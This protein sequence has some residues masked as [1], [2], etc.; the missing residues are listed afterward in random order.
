[1]REILIYQYLLIL[2]PLT[3]YGFLEPPQ[4]NLAKHKK[5]IATSTCGEL[6]GKPYREIFCSLAS[7]L[8]YTPYQQMTSAID[9]N[10]FREAR[11]EHSFLREGQS[12]DICEAN[13]TLEH[14][15]SNM[16]DGSN[17]WWQSPPL[18][19]GREYEKVNITIDLGQ[20]FHV[21]YIYIAM[22][23]SP[24]PATWVLERSTDSGKTFKPWQYFAEHNSDCARYFGYSSLAPITEDDSV[25]CSSEYSKLQPMDNGEI[26]INLLEN[27][28]GRLNFSNSPVLQEFA[29]ATN[30]RLRLLSVATLHGNLM[31][32][33]RGNDPT[34]TRRYFYAIKE[35]K[36]GG[37]CACHGHAKTC[38]YL[39]K[40]RSDKLICRCEHNTCGDRCDMCCPG[41]EQKKWQLSRSGQ[42]FECEKCNC[43]GHTNDCVYDEE[44]DRINGSI[45]IH[46]KYSGGGRCLNCQHN[47]KG[48]NCNECVDG[49]YKPEGKKWSDIDVCKKCS[50]DPSKHTGRCS[51][52]TGKCECLPQFT[53]ENC[54][55]CSPGY[56]DEPECKPCECFYQGTVGNVCLPIGEKCPCKANYE[57]QFCDYC[58]PGYFNL[59]SG[60]EK[61][62]CDIDGA[63]NGECDL[64]T[65]ACKCKTNYGGEKCDKCAVGYYNYPTCTF[66]QCDPSG[67]EGGMCDSTTGQCLCKIG[68]SGDKCDQCEENYY[69]YPN[70]KPCNCDS[71]G[72]NSTQCHQTT[73]ECPC[74]ENFAGRVCDKCVPGYYAY[75][76][77]LPC[78]CFAQGSKGKTC[79]SK[80]N[81][82]CKENFQGKRCEKCKDNFFNFPICEECNCDPDGVTKDFGGCDKVSPGELCECKNN[83][84]GRTCNKCKETFWDLKRYHEEGCIS[85]G[86]DT[87]G[88][89]S[90]LNLCDEKK[91]QCKCKLHISGRRCEKCK[92]GFYNKNDI[93]FLGCQS[94]KCN[95]A[96]SQGNTCNGETGQ[97]HCK[98]R[99]TG[100]KCD[101]PIEKH[102]FPT[103]WHMQYEAEDGK[104]PENKGVRFSMDSEQFGNFSWRGF[105]VFSHIQE[106]VHLVADVMKT[107]VYKILAH[108]HNPTN[109]DNE[110]SVSITPY[111]LVSQEQPQQSFESIISPSSMPTTKVINPDNKPIPISHGRHIIKF[112]TKKRL[113]LDYIVLLP[114]EYYEG[115]NLKENIDEICKKGQKPEEFCVKLS[116]PPMGNTIKADKPGEILDEIIFNVPNAG[117]YVAI[118]TYNYD[119]PEI[120]PAS[121][122]DN[123][124]AFE[125][126][127]NFVHC[128]YQT[129][130]RELAVHKGTPTIFNISKSGEYKINLKYV[131]Q[132]D[133]EIKGIE[134]VPLNE[135]KDSYLNFHH[136]CISLNNKCI[137][138]SYPDAQSGIVTEIEES[139]GNKPILGEK[140]PFEIAKK[141][142]V[143]VMSLDTSQ[144]TIEINGIVDKE[145][146]YNFI[147]DYYNPNGKERTLNVLFNDNNEHTYDAK[148]NINYCPSHSGC[149]SI[150]TFDQGQLYQ[151]VKDK[152]SLTIIG[153]ED[154]YEPIYFDAITAVPSQLFNQNLLKLQPLDV[155]KEFTSKC[156]KNFF[157]NDP[158]SVNEFCKEKIFSLA[159]DF[160]GQAQPCSCSAS[161]SLSFNCQEYGGQCSCKPNVIGRKCD[162][163]APGYYSFPSCI[164]CNCGP[165]ESCDEYTGQ[166][167][168]PQHV[169]GKSCDKC[170]KYAYGYDP[171]IG[172]QLCGCNKDGS[173]GGELECDPLSGQCLCKDNVGGRKCDSCLAGFYRFPYCSECNCDTRGTTPDICNSETSEC[174]CKKNVG[175]RNCNHCL[176]GT[177]DLTDKNP[178]GCSS[179]FCFGTTDSCIS[180][181]FNVYY[182]EFD[183]FAWKSDDVN[184]VVSG[185]NGDITYTPSEDKSPNNVY[186]IYSIDN[187]ND[188]TGIYGQLIS[189]Y[190]S[191]T[192]NDKDKVFSNEPD[193]RLIGEHGIAEAW[194]PSQPADPSKRFVVSI[195]LLPEFW[196]TKD[197]DHVTRADLMMILV[198]LKEIQVKVS[199]YER[200]LKAHIYDFKMTRAYPEEK[201]GF[202]TVSRSTSVEKCECPPSYT[203]P[204]CQECALGYYRIKSGDYLGS[205]VPC[206]CNGH[207]GNCDKDTGICQDCLHNTMGDHCEICI[208]GFYGNAT[209]GTEYDCLSCPCPLKE[210]GENFAI[211][212]DVHENG[213]PEKCY[214]KEGYTGEICDRCDTG[215]FGTPFR[216]DG[217][218]QKCFCNN[219]NNL[220]VP[221]SCDDVKGFCNY[222]QNNTSG[223]YCE[224]C[225]DWFYGDAVEAKNCTACNCVIEGTEECDKTSGQCICLENVQGE[226]CNECIPEAYG[227]DSGEGCKMCNCAEA[228]SSKQCNLKTGQCACMPGVTGLHCD[229]C[230]QGFWN[231]S[232]EGCTKCDCEADLSKGTVCDVNTGQCHCQ[233]GAT[234]PRCD[235]C[236]A[237]FLKIPEYGCR[238]CDNCVFSLRD[239]LDVME[240]TLQTVIETVDST[241]PAALVGAKLNKYDKEYKIYDPLIQKLITQKDN[242]TF[243]N[244]LAEVEELKKNSSL[245]VIRT[246]M[247]LNHLT[248]YIESIKSLINETIELNGDAKYMY[249]TTKNIVDGI[250]EIPTLFMTKQN[251]ENREY[252][253]KGA[254]NI[255]STMKS[256]DDFEKRK[257]K[258]TKELDEIMDKINDVDRRTS[259][260]KDLKKSIN[261]LGKE[262]DESSKLTNEQ[263]EQLI[264]VS[265]IVKQLNK[266]LNEN[267]LFR[268][269]AA[270]KGLN[271][272][273][274]NLPIMIANI[275]KKINETKKI[276]D[277]YTNILTQLVDLKTTL[278]T[279]TN[280]LKNQNDKISRKKRAINSSQL[281]DNVIKLERQSNEI[282]KMFENTKRVS[283]NAVEAG[284][285]YQNITDIIRNAD[286]TITKALDTCE[287]G[288]KNS[289]GLENVVKEIKE[290]NGKITNTIN[291]IRKD[292]LNDIELKNHKI[293]ENLD[294]LKEKVGDLKESVDKH[295]EVHNESLDDEEFIKKVAETK[296]SLDDI[297]NDLNS[298][299]VDSDNVV[300]ATNNF[301]NECSRINQE[302]RGTKAQVSELT[303]LSEP[304][305]EKMKSFEKKITNFT[306]HLTT[307]QAKL[308]VLR[309]KIDIARNMANRIKLGAHFERG[310][311]LELNVKGKTQDVAGFSDISFYMRTRSLSGL[312]MYF[313]NIGTSSSIEYIAM[314]L[315]SGRPKVSINLGKTPI[316]V[317]LNTLVNDN[318]WR[319]YR[320]ERIGRSI[321]IHVSKP[322]SLEN[323]ETKQL[324]LPSDKHVLNIDPSRG[325]LLLGGITDEVLPKK[326]VSKDFIGSIEEFRINNIYNSLWSYKKQT[327]V[328]GALVRPI[329][330]DELTSDGVSFDGNGYIALPHEKWDVTK[331]TAFTMSFQTYVSNGL[332][333]FLGKDNDYLMVKIENGYIKLLINLGSGDI[334]I[335]SNKNTYADGHWHSLRVD[336]LDRKARLTVDDVDKSEG[337]T[338]GSMSELKYDK[339]YY[340]GDVGYD[341]KNKYQVIPFRGCIKNFKIENNFVDLR[342][343]LSSKGVQMSCPTQII[344]LATFTTPQS[345][346][347]FEKTLIDKNIE[348]SLKYKTVQNKLTLFTLEDGNNSENEMSF[349]IDNGYIYLLLGGEEFGKSD[350]IS[351]S[352]GNWHI[353]S[354]FID[355]NSL[356]IFVDDILLKT[357]EKPEYIGDNFKEVSLRIGTN[358]EKCDP[359]YCIGDLILNQKLINLAE[360]VVNDVKLQQCSVVTANEECISTLK[361]FTS[362]SENTSAEKQPVSSE[363]VVY[364][365]PS[366]EDD[367]IPLTE[368]TLSLVVYDSESCYTLGDSTGENRG[369]RFGL[370]QYS[371]VE[372][373]ESPELLSSNSM[374]ISVMVKPTAANGLISYISNP[375]T[376][377]YLSIYLMEGFVHFSYGNENN[378]IDLKSKINILDNKWHTIRAERE[379]NVGILQI[380]SK[381]EN[382][383]QTTGDM[384]IIGL[385]SPVFF[386][387]LSTDVQTTY[388]KLFPNMTI[389]FTGCMSDFKL[390]EKD[391]TE[392][393]NEI[394]V[395]NCSEVNEIGMFFGP[396][397]GYA[398]L[399]QDFS[400]GS[401]FKLEFE[402]K[403]RT[404]DAI[405]LSIGVDDAFNFQLIN[406]T[407][408]L[409]VSTGNVQESIEFLTPYSGYFC[410]GQWHNI[411]LYK[412]KN[413]ISLSVNGK[414]KFLFLK[415]KKKTGGPVKDVLYLG[416][417]P[418]DIKPRGLETTSSYHGCVRVS[419]FDKKSK[420]ARKQ[421]N[422][423]DKVQHFGDIVPNLCPLH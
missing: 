306:S 101:K 273:N 282:K 57:G 52:G 171:L 417:I 26:Y 228:S 167:S 298:I 16:V 327:N 181:M 183:N 392:K 357:T 362:S 286:N 371:R 212:C 77:C 383:G 224:E 323:E 321:S 256:N 176:R 70:C 406:G 374:A 248:E 364:T 335:N 369:I 275:D 379:K 254:S 405:L 233:P 127:V 47:T 283:G 146:Y 192:P 208:E 154:L 215:Y 403:P 394:G 153:E 352:D 91:G 25:V 48:I 414:S 370:E 372:Y 299:I 378:N 278:Q 272:G 347:K 244:E 314:N 115:H 187:D 129:P 281:N 237:N 284:N 313:G 11:A 307:A 279:Y 297:K 55:Q 122:W 37:T 240:G 332:L 339:L 150:V 229:R 220:T 221:G 393:R 149:R 239:M 243:L 184:G 205:C 416:G 360:G 269:N 397:G 19:R 65:G 330:K 411:I 134:L 293:D 329:F 333:F 118:F 108:Y 290:E 207:S 348:I 95:L 63:A 124:K 309:E 385:Q 246:N 67:T 85:C 361:P 29:R 105:V 59:T 46:G 51:E 390:N 264:N 412:N 80:G 311:S 295:K 10:P 235:Q 211:G 217:S 102:F 413:L 418:K 294:E 308:A 423:L 41:F 8:P 263:L 165:N 1:M 287:T 261:N 345:S 58:S 358:D 72:S 166:C 341:T 40:S 169:E 175:G 49:Y 177:F 377:E 30:V 257:D 421:I 86:C 195:Q 69:G 320:I 21:A 138:Q 182:E 366:D 54:D 56:Y 301:T 202:F 409:T 2:L 266:T 81:C 5:I 174:I 172:C 289:D 236:I 419:T 231:Y 44:L 404:K 38:D 22:A 277:E 304:T 106:E 415:G 158:E 4:F 391:F 140:L 384:D 90:G 253:I 302:I 274:Q 255:L 354:L 232:P 103:L 197:G 111:S 45:D 189:Y 350:F 218:C 137:D 7:S 12:C 62:D 152:Y 76:N 292:I 139:D 267:I 214:C 355:R 368:T 331:K 250:R 163:C 190:A 24:R 338:L 162:R 74:R 326:I 17:A 420:R 145:N 316:E 83:V 94:C 178:E 186:L 66:C 386:G 147:V 14:P 209:S 132:K 88:T 247:T 234:G 296:K 200:P 31:D 156:S 27:R 400:V 353:A 258:I 32:I 351:A 168:C 6:H 359:K 148:L 161:G 222:C 100:E 206:E 89:L 104:T 18:S 324:I 82:H 399:N 389:K 119:R 193:I 219:N 188:Y 93:N 121:I 196:V 422:I 305:I 99:V 143:N 318:S 268:I 109:V 130:C 271:D 337:E 343:A 135:W 265:S 73:G 334:E 227:F 34:V 84:V 238:Q 216:S 310:S 373:N 381:T 75:P 198:K 117:E 344:R 42:F 210:N 201:N 9:G 23:N 407:L 155:G 97:C 33:H 241:P 179:C 363:E 395:K 114:S 315:V 50:C 125:G 388:S 151:Y 285:V 107:S 170:V 382:E 303:K 288:A 203:G 173:E 251:I 260:N 160:N 15:A 230:M 144:N 131:K 356:K 291:S 3:I 245:N 110:V 71:S 375:S 164:K 262:I 259:K 141:N 87:T 78:N 180:S 300:E 98:P 410:D 402:I 96:T 367:N 322:M 376:T 157:K 317:T 223:L 204:S 342:K 280:D 133:L 159:I 53:G 20:E 336:R 68:F 328:T 116:Y 249:Q 185:N 380:D 319:F 123:K 43:H 252:L 199:Y 213:L 112:K 113:Y 35:I 396:S 13:T 387:G 346:I 136:V 408:K 60:C 39:D 401:N 128:P 191:T 349:V 276:L 79:D 226:T 28:P 398:V 126:V 225:E 242:E 64:T 92:D 120:E 270:I 365:L 61:C 325:K 340:L 312:V 142:K 194:L 36:I